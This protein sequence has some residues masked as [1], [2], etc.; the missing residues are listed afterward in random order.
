[1]SREIQIGRIPDQTNRDKISGIPRTVIP[2]GAALWD[3]SNRDESKFNE[4]AAPARCISWQSQ[5]CS[6]ALIAA[7]LSDADVL[8]T[9]DQDLRKRVEVKAPGRVWS[10][11]DFYYP[12]VYDP[13]CVKTPEAPKPGEIFSQIARNPPRSETVIALIAIRKDSRSFNFPRRRVFTQ[14]RPI[15]DINLLTGLPPV[16][17]YPESGRVGEHLLQIH[18]DQKI[19]FDNE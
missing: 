14:P 3:Y 6:D 8:V 19:V 10:F 12:T 1:M 5:R 9:E 16:R 13:G 7:T 11:E 18:R 15:R 17:P 2:T 4:G